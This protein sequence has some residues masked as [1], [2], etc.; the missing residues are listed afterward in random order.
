MKKKDEIKQAQK[1]IMNGKM[2]PDEVDSI[3][4]LISNDESLSFGEKVE[5]IINYS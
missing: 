3:Y 1:L 5:A 2:H 4:A